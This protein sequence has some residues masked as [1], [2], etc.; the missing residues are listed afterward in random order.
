M[1]ANLMQTTL[2]NY[3]LHFSRLNAV[4]INGGFSLLRYGYG[5]SICLRENIHNPS[6]G[7][8]VFLTNTYLQMRSSFGSG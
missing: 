8:K 1:V 4:S 5:Y 7:R 6:P 2:L 3:R